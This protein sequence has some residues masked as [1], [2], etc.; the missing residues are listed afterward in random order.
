VTEKPS[1]A[2]RV[3]SSPIDGGGHVSRCLSLAKAMRPRAQIT[4]I[5]DNTGAQWKTV[6]EKNGFDAKLQNETGETNWTGCLLDGYRLEENDQDNW[7][8]LTGCLV[9]IDD[10]GNAS[11]DFDI[12]LRPTAA[13]GKAFSTDQTLL[14]GLKYA[15]IDPDYATQ[16]DRDCSA[17]VQNILVSLGYQDSHN[18]N[19]KVIL[20]LNKMSRSKVYF[21]PEILIA[22][23]SDAPHLEELR[24]E[25]KNSPLCIKI[26][27]DLR[28]LK[29]EMTK[30]DLMIGAGGVTL[31]ERMA[32]GLPSLSIA[33]A[34]NQL[35]L[36]K[37]ASERGATQECAARSSDI[38]NN[39]NALSGNPD[40]RQNMSDIAQK[41]VDGRGCERVATVLLG[42]RP[43]NGSVRGMH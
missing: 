36:V 11:S 21:D 6:I 7:R 13:N 34:E 23:G 41:L 9:T 19:A 20:A 43:E 27:T 10:F 25:A 14:E 18:V 28:D 2:L 26:E 31:L 40:F 37:I 3:G 24:L 29:D 32:A 5:L 17:P 22:I 16:S 33:V 30:S 35:P 38:C 15:L 8:R 4:F 42:F 1:W 39:L 12:I